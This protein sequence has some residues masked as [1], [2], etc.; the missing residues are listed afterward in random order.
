MTV[1]ENFKKLETK[2]SIELYIEKMINL[3]N[4]SLISVLGLSL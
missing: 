2:C 1:N 3:M 4:K